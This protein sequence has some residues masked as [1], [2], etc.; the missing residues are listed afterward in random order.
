MPNSAPSDIKYQPPVKGYS[1]SSPEVVQE[2]VVKKKKSIFYTLGLELLGLTFLFFIFLVILNY[3]N[4]LSLSQI[5]P[6]QLGWL[7]HISSPVKQNI[8]NNNL[9]NTGS[10][11]NAGQPIYL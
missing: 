8:I 1:Y 9:T 2:E 4:I 3:F 10:S 6:D 5:Y 11:P 7:P